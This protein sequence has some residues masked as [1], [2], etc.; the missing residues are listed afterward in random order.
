M[1]FQKEIEI[2]ESVEVTIDGKSV[3]VKGPKG[4][5]KRMFNNPKYNKYIKIEKKDNKII[6]YATIERKKVKA[7]IGT[8]KAHIKNMFLGVTVGFKYTMKIYYIHFPMSVA[9]N[10]GYVE[11]KN[12][13]GERTIRKAKIVGNCEVKIEKD[14]I[15][16]TGIDIEEVGATATN[17]E[18][19]SK[20]STRDKRIFLDG[21]YLSGRFLQN[22]EEL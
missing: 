18:N 22:G 19:V 11:I 10:D 20:I 12:F 14:E 13:L 16:I 17:I 4:E 6:V 21:I 9:V 7:M 8:I 15:I 5:L 2:P 1:F 3:L